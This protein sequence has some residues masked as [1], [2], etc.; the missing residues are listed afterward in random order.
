M[1]SK[2]A[3]QS[4]FAYIERVCPCLCVWLQDKISNKHFGLVNTTIEQRLLICVLIIFGRV[5]YVPCAEPSLIII[6]ISRGGE[7]HI[8]L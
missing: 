6:P 3:K 7:S 8:N 5:A 4:R 1:H 2:L